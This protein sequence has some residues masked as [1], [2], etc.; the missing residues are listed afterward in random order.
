M[1]DLQYTLLLKLSTKVHGNRNISKEYLD[2]LNSDIA[3]KCKSLN[4]KMSTTESNMNLIFKTIYD[5]LKVKLSDYEIE[6]ILKNYINLLLADACDDSIVD[7][8]WIID[9]LWY[10]CIGNSKIK[11]KYKDCITYIQTKLMTT[12][13]M[14]ENINSK[15][16]RNIVTNFYINI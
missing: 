13:S 4:C 16:K 10:L 1:N 11:D 2:E 7:E 15:V 8:S 6:H 12:F 9:H 14:K 5:V 3:Q